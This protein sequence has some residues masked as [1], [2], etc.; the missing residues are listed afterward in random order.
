MKKS[1]LYLLFIISI[2]LIN[3]VFVQAQCTNEVGVTITKDSSVLSPCV[4]LNARDSIILKAGF[5]CSLNGYASSSNPAFNAS[6]D[7]SLDLPAN[8]LT[9]T[10]DLSTRKVDTNLPFGTLTGFFN[11]TPTGAAT[12]EIPISVPKG[13]NNLEPKISVIYNSQTGNGLLGWGC[14]L[15]GLSAITRVPKNLYSDNRVSGLAID[16]TDRFILDGN[17]LVPNTG[18]YGADES[19][20]RTEN[21]TFSHIISK[22]IYGKNSPNWFEV[23]TKNGTK[24]VYGSPNGR[25]LYSANGTNAILAWY[26][27]SVVDVSG[28]TIS[29]TYEQKGLVTYLKKISYGTNKSGVGTSSSLEFFYEI[30]NDPINIHYF[31]LKGQ[32][33]QELYKIVTKTGNQ[34]FRTYN[35]EYTQDA[36]SRLSKITESNGNGTK[37]NPTYLKWGDYNSDKVT[38]NNPLLPEDSYY[39]QVNFSQRNWTTGDVNGDGLTDLISF[40]PYKHYS[41]Y[42]G[43]ESWSQ[44]NVV[45]I[46]YA[47]ISPEGITSFSLGPNYEYIPN[48]V[49]DDFKCYSSTSCVQ[50]LNGDNIPDIIVPYF[51]KTNSWNEIDF[52]VLNYNQ[53]TPVFA[54][55]LLSSTDKLPIYAIGDLN[56]DGID[57][58]IYIEDSQSSSMNYPGKIRFGSTN[59]DNNWIN[60]NVSTTN[61]PKNIFIADFNADGLNDIMV[62]TDNEYIIYLNN[63]DNTFTVGD[64]VDGILNSTCDIIKTGDFNGDGL[65]DFV[66]NQHESPNWYLLLNNGNLGFDQKL[67]PSVTAQ[68]EDY[69]DKDDATHNCIVT[70]FN[71]DGKSDLIVFDADYEFGHNSFTGESWGIFNYFNTYWYQSTGDNVS[72]SKTTA[73][74]HTEDDAQAKLFVSG[75]FNGD[76]R[77]DLMNFGYDCY[78]ATDMTQRWR[79]YSTPNT[80]FGGGMVTSLFDGLGQNTR[81]SYITTAVGI[82]YSSNSNP[83]FPLAL[84]RNSAYL[85]KKVTIPNGV[86]SDIVKKYS[87][88]NATQD[89]QRGFLGFGKFMVYDSLT[90]TSSE[91]DYEFSLSSGSKNYIQPFPTYSKTIV[92]STVVSDSNTPLSSYSLTAFPNG[93]KHVFIYP[94]ISTQTDYLKKI[95]TTSIVSYDNN[96][97]ILS[98]EIDY[99]DYTNP[100]SNKIVASKKN[101]YNG[102][103]QRLKNNLNPYPNAPDNVVTEQTHKDTDGKFSITTAFEY[104]DNGTVK[105]KTDFSGTTKAVSTELTYDEVGNVISTTVGDRR[106]SAVY[107]DDKRFIKKQFNSLNHYTETSYD[108]WG[109]PLVK[110]DLNRLPTTFTFDDWDGLTSTTFSDATKIVSLINWADNGNFTSYK[111]DNAL[112]YVSSVDEDNHFISAEYFDAVGHLLRE[113]VSGFNGK[114][115][116]S[117]CKYNSLGQS[118]IFSDPYPPSGSATKTTTNLYDGYGRLTEQTLP[119][120][121]TDTISYSDDIDRKTTTH[122]ST[123]ETYTETYDAAGLLTSTTDP[124]GSISYL[125]YKNSNPRSIQPNGGSGAETITYFDETGLQKTLTD[126]DAGTTSYDYNIYGELSSQTDALNNQTTIVYDSIGRVKTKTIGNLITNYTYDAPGTI[127]LLSGVNNSN[128]G[129]LYKYDSFD[130]IIEKTRSKGND[131]F[132]FTYEYD[133]KSRVSKLTYPNNMSLTYGYNDISNDLISITKDGI[134]IWSLNN[135]DVN[136]LGQIT[137]VTLGNGKSTIYGYD[138]ENRLNR[139]FADNVVDFNYQFNN[140]QQLDYR[141]EYMFDGSTMNG[142]QENFTYDNVNRLSTVSVGNTETLHMTYKSG[143]NDRIDNKSDV[144]TY[145]YNETSKH[146]IDKLAAAT[147]YRPPRHDLTYNQLGKVSAIMETDSLK[148]KSLSIDYGVDDQRFKTVYSQNDTTKYIWYYFDNYEKQIMENGAVRHLNYIFAGNSLIGIFEQKSDGDKIH[149]VYSDYLGSLKCITDNLGTNEQRL[150]FDVWGNRRNPY[151][152]TK[153]T[154]AELE[155]SISLTSRGYVGQEHL[156]NLGL[157]NMN[158]RIYDPSLGLFISP[159]NY[160][161][162]IGYSQAFNRYNYGLNNPLMYSDPN[163]NFPFLMVGILLIDA[164]AFMRSYGEINNN[165][166]LYTVGN[167]AMLGGSLLSGYGFTS[168]GGTAAIFGNGMMSGFDNLIYGGS[169]EKGFVSGAAF[170]AALVGLNWSLGKEWLWN[171]W[172]GYEP[173]YKWISPNEAWH[174]NDL[175]RLTSN[176]YQ[177]VNALGRYLFTDAKD[178]L[179]LVPAGKMVNIEYNFSTNIPGNFNPSSNYTTNID[180]GT[181]RGNSHKHDLC[182]SRIYD[183]DFDFSTKASP[184]EVRTP[185]NTVRKHIIGMGSEMGFGGIKDFRIN[186]NHYSV[187]VENP[188]GG[189]GTETAIFHNLHVQAYSRYGQP[190]C[191][192]TQ[193][194][195]ST[196]RP[197][198]HKWLYG[199]K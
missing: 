71:N 42:N 24:Y 26:L 80:N 142:F 147:G 164:G 199:I 171:K 173:H 74:S 11:V 83:I 51:N 167:Y 27:D 91:Q 192:G 186:H 125:Y 61:A 73:T 96:G 55:K 43:G 72:L 158:A 165:T 84:L 38:L 195:A 89:L 88:A 109:N 116:Y 122:Y 14:N 76:G 178:I 79:L 29:Y 115:T 175:P 161:D 13:L 47:S 93:L 123:G 7:E 10:P 18:I 100:T 172:F 2:F 5:Y 68:N 9:N 121:V 112:Y 157:I 134:N 154:T 188:V 86:S 16:T 57:D 46:F 63:G 98:N 119:D 33:D 140:K 66:I 184:V 174:L 92:G 120:A 180:P 48:L 41:Y 126:P 59:W 87:Y 155:N 103:A 191:T 6:V 75:D 128:G 20:Y 136:D 50:N 185:G 15:S 198:Y 107:T 21:E 1:F 110:W 163:G 17:R 114:V 102:Y 28:N 177:S 135:S 22:G 37:L 56:N 23:Y 169:F 197:W 90:N 101:I 153:L 54:Q 53:N 190:L 94:S 159:D 139:I 105:K 193:F 179:K 118:W 69:T 170:S 113:A 85:V 39:N 97:N 4:N 130:R 40:F 145:I 183:G 52:F 143:V 133:N 127:G 176:I 166:T 12:Y 189:Q 104:N 151:T 77:P 181:I 137:K 82:N 32:I 129:M 141:K 65:V 156:D 8:Y 81:I 148:S 30:R 106:D 149:Y 25:T 196:Q 95:T 132:T 44:V 64:L 70:D 144:G 58:I 67:L 3:I 150:S 78:G 36:F 99:T 111:P 152:G 138:G 187:T 49:W 168:I 146:C 160:M 62:L 131:K 117:D 194:M 19:T 35:F 60:F 182:V 124:G 162:D 45:Q 108:N 34:V 31:P